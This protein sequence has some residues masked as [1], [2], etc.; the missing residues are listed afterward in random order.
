MTAGNAGTDFWSRVRQ[1]G[2]PC[3]LSLERLRQLGGELWRSDSGQPWVS[4]GGHSVLETH[5]VLLQQEPVRA[6]SEDEATPPPAAKGGHSYAR[7]DTRF[8]FVGHTEPIG[9]LLNA[10]VCCPISSLG[11]ARLFYCRSRVE[12]AFLG[13]YSTVYQFFVSED[14]EGPLRFFELDDS[15][16]LASTVLEF[17]ADED[18]EADDLPLAFLDE[19]E[20]DRTARTRFLYR[21]FY[22]ETLPGRLALLDPDRAVLHYDRPGASVEETFRA[23]LVSS[24]QQVVL[25]RAC[26]WAIVFLGIAGLALI[27]LR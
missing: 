6:L 5:A 12:L 15:D 27:A 8:C 22:E 14:L 3:R 16:S 21:R 26:F 19:E 9:T 24:Q 13:P 4:L 1:E 25:L 10:L 2:G 11:Q 7:G 20:S 23:L 17:E 18:A